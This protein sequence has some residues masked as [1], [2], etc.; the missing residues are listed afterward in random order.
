M[1]TTLDLRAPRRSLAFILGMPLAMLGANFVWTSYNSIL[2][3]PLVQ[4]VVAPGAAQVA[5]GVIAFISTLVGIVMSLVSG[6]LS[7]RSTSAWGRRTPLLLT[8]SLLALPFIA[9]A[10]WFRLSLPLIMISYLGMQVFTNIANGAWW[11]LLVD[12]VPEEQRGLASGIQG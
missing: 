12:V 4:Q 5:V 9:L 11:P 2:L 7:D 1:A 3:L 8:G 6:I 10:A